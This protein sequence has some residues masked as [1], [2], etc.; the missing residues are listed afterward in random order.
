M[1]WALY[2]GAVRRFGLGL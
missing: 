1:L 2:Q